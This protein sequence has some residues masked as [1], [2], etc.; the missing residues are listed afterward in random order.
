[1]KNEYRIKIT[2][3]ALLIV[4][5]TAAALVLGNRS[6]SVKAQDTQPMSERFAFGIVGFTEGQTMRINV[7]NIV[8]A[9]DSTLPPG[10]S[11]VAIIVVNSRGQVLRNRRGE[12]IRRVVMLDRGDSAL[13]DVDFDE[14]PPSPIRHHARAIVNVLPPG[15]YNLNMLPGPV[16][17]TVEVFNNSNGRTQFMHPAVIRG[18]NP[19]P[20]PPIE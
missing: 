11:R 16:M 4:L 10:P 15:P 1:M 5:V 7:S 12:P 3:T 8:A 6:Q 20:D 13:L 17:P 14:L 18:F 19:Q 2:I 9:N